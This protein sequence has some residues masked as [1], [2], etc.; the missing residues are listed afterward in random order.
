MWLF[1]IFVAVPIIEIA[2]FINLGSRLGVFP[3]LAIV[4][5]TAALG[6]YLVKSQAISTFE[7]IKL[8]LR[9]LQ[10]PTQTV[11]HAA[12]I[13]FAGVLLVTPG[14]FTDLIGFMLLVPRLR[15]YIINI[16]NKKILDKNFVFDSN[17]RT[18]NFKSSDASGSDT[19]I[20]GEYW[21]NKSKNPQSGKSDGINH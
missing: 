11:A 17:R 18:K 2:L 14:F 19:I 7:T 21:E 16:V 5:I 3:T 6:T 1:V 12:T 8:E 20:E 9:N 4:L 15:N 10:N 13:L